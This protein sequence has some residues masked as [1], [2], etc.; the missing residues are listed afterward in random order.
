MIGDLDSDKKELRVAKGGENGKG[1]KRFPSL[2]ASH[3]KG[4]P[5][6]E[7]HLYLELKSLAQV[8]L[9][10]LPNVGKSTLLAALTRALPKI[11]NYE[12]TTLHPSVGVMRFVDDVQISIADI[13]GIIEDAHLNKGLGL[14][15]LRHIE[16]TKT[17][18]FVLD[19]T[20]SDPVGQFELLKK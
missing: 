2:D 9:V 5:G 15:F 18:L 20:R 10:G 4:K 3:R 1:N 12:L 19:V 14:E 16:R 7:R 13:P 6:Q 11:A 17:L 8:G